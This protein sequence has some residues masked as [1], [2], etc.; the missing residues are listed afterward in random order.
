MRTAISD[1][2]GMVKQGVRSM[3][4]VAELARGSKKVRES[5]AT[6]LTKVLLLFP[7]FSPPSSST[8]GFKDFFLAKV[9]L[10][11]KNTRGWSE[12]RVLTTTGK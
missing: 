3:E 7:D 2:L 12:D 11:V 6:V 8:V 1:P 5:S 10:Q 4:A 9:A